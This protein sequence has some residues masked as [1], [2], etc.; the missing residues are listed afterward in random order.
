M[1]KKQYLKSRASRAR[2][3]MWL[4]VPHTSPKHMHTRSRTYAAEGG[5]CTAVVLDVEVGAKQT[6]GIRLRGRSGCWGSPTRLTRTEVTKGAATHRG[7]EQEGEA[8]SGEPRKAGLR[9]ER[10]QK[11]LSA[12]KKR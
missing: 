1:D 8:L 10:A 7:P 12:C 9:P 11:T 5:R 3:A 6:D 2:E 4:T